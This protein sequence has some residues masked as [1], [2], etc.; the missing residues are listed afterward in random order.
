MIKVKR[1]ANSGSI[2]ENFLTTRP[3][4]QELVASFYEESRGAQ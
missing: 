1:N 2:K 4:Q 3:V